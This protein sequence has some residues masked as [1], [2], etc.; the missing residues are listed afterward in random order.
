VSVNGV[1][2]VPE[3]ARLTVVEICGAVQ[4]PDEGFVAVNAGKLTVESVGE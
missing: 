3:F 4:E 1:A 2:T